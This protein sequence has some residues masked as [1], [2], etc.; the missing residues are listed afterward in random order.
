MY[1][2]YFGN[3]DGWELIATVDDYKKFLEGQFIYEPPYMIERII[4]DKTIE[5]DYGSYKN[6]YKVLKY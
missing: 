5:V 2:V 6:Y 3:K 4:D 1:K